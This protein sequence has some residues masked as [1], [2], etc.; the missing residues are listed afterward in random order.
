[1]DAS[2]LNISMHRILTRE[3]V[4]RGD[5]NEESVKIKA[6]RLGKNGIPPSQLIQEQKLLYKKMKPFFDRIDNR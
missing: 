3:E 5:P 6:S 4:E 2:K 1:V